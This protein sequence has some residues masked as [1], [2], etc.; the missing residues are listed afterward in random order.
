MRSQRIFL[1]PDTEK[2]RTKVC[3]PER[4]KKIE[5]FRRESKDLRTNLTVNVSSVRR[6]FDALRLLRMTYRVL[7]LVLL[8]CLGSHRTW[9]AGSESAP[10][11]GLYRFS[12]MKMTPRFR[13][14]GESALASKRRTSAAGPHVFYS[15]I[16]QQNLRQFGCRASRLRR[17]WAS[18][19][20]PGH[21]SEPELRPGP[22]PG[23]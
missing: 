10:Q 23:W 21:P 2:D 15:R 22:C 13:G 20:Q 18:E 1:P 3:H 17:G 19:R 16:D 11:E 6:S 14:N 12:P 9:S 7:W 4:L 5:D 8:V